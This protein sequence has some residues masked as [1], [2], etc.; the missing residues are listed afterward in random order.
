MKTNTLPY[1]LFASAI[2]I[3]LVA[4]VF[5]IIGLSV[6]FSGAFW[7]VIIMGSV[8][9]VAKLVT[10]VWL[11]ANWKE[12]SLL[13]KSYLSIAVLVLI[14]IT[15]MGIFGYLSKAH[16]EHERQSQK[17]AAVIS[18]IDNKIERESVEIKRLNEAIEQAKK[19]LK[20]FTSR[21]DVNFDREE[22]KIKSISVS[23][24][25]DIKI[26]QQYISNLTDRRKDLDA[27]V[28]AIESKGGG[29]F[30]NKKKNLEALK[31]AQDAERREIKD[32]IVK[33]ET[34]INSHRSN[35]AAE[36]KK[37]RD[38][39]DGYQDKDLTSQ[40]DLDTLIETSTQKIK[41]TQDSIE[42]LELRKFEE[43]DS[44]SAMEAEIGPVK[45]VAE[46]LR[47]LRIADL[48]NDSAV[49]MI[50]TII[51]LV[52]DPLAVLM[53]LAATSTIR[54]SKEK[55]KKERVSEQKQSTDRNKTEEADGEKT[56]LKK[57]KTR[58]PT[59][60]II[61]TQVD[62]VEDSVKIVKAL[63]EYQEEY[64][65]RNTE[66]DKENLSDDKNKENLS[67]DKNGKGDAGWAR[68]KKNLFRNKS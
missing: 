63:N 23:L 1:L 20:D 43:S 15:S 9:E 3:S 61:A 6:I 48:E 50:T 46:I 65:Q 32:K 49:R 13:L 30:S 7:S 45:Y 60:K 36:I 57:E 66:E 19:R 31:Q 56:E 67:D 25:K 27:E 2:S 28:I 17:V 21:T 16:I 37:I 12:T 53:L 5:S 58:R 34:I 47:E 8:L 59:Y 55:I 18:Q 64:E 62:T 35:A 26:E 44:L 10:A 42:E 41:S 33:Y 11:H 54:I 51:M 38:K 22:D 29:L 68:N 52:F 40:S 24:D 39:I 14:G 4:G